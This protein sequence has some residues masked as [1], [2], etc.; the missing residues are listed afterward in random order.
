[1]L[2]SP[3]EEGVPGGPCRRLSR[4]CGSCV[5]ADQDGSLRADDRPAGTP[6]HPRGRRD[7]RA[8]QRLL[9]AGRSRRAAGRVHAGQPGRAGLQLGADRR[10]GQGGRGARPDAVSDG[11]WRAG[12][13]REGRAAPDAPR[14]VPDRIVEAGP[15][16]GGPLRPRARPPLRRHHR[17]PSESPVL[18]GLERAEPEP[19]PQPAG[20]EEEARRRG[21]LP[22][23]GQLV[24][25]GRARGA[26]EQRG[27]R[28]VAVR[29]QLPDAIRASRHRA[30]A[31]HAPH[32]VHVRGE[33]AARDV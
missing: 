22:R 14:P 10:A 29:L 23:S 28:R 7:V 26:R 9:G 31:V 15:G 30:A 24:R 13:G 8:D 32:A 6:A 20:E 11:T 27:C 16:P 21:R 18:R 3:R 33:H 1:M 5:R 2:P 4:A 17:R 25:R 12:L 19:V